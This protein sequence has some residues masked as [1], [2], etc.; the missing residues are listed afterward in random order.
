MDDDVRA[1]VCRPLA[2]GN[3]CHDLNDLAECET[4]MVELDSV[5]TLEYDV[6]PFVR[7]LGWELL[8]EP[9]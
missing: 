9:I 4:A 5:Y 3:V 1:G 6:S 2:V 7:S 8:S